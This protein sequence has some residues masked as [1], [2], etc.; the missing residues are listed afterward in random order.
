MRYLAE[1]PWVPTALLPSQGVVWEAMDDS[2]ARATLSDAGITVTAVFHFGPRG[3]IVRVEAERYRDVKG[4][5]VLTPWGGRFHEYAEI[6]GMRIPMQGEVEW[7]LP[8]GRLSYWRGRITR[9]EYQF[10]Q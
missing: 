9:A 2:R 5:G 10:A 3:E 7:I 6:E 8:E 4:V 1:A